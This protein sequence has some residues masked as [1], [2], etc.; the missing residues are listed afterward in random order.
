MRLEPEPNRPSRHEVIVTCP[1]CG[2]VEVLQRNITAM[3]LC[4]GCGAA[5]FLTAPKL[6]N[7]GWNLLPPINAGWRMEWPE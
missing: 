4:H 5:A 7:L 6:R 3:Y 2:M 1:R